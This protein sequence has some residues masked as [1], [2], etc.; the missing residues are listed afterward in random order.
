MKHWLWTLARPWYALYRTL[1]LVNL[2]MKLR[3]AFLAW[4]QWRRAKRRDHQ[5][6]RDKEK[7]KRREHVKTQVKLDS[8]IRRDEERKIE[9]YFRKKELES[10]RRRQKEGGTKEWEREYKE[11]QR[12]H[13]ERLK[14]ADEKGY[15]LSEISS[16][17]LDSIKADLEATRKM[18]REKR[19]KPRKAIREKERKLQE[20]RNERRARK[21]KKKRRKAKKRREERELK[22]L[23][24]VKK[25]SAFLKEDARRRDQKMERRKEA[26]AE[27]YMREMGNR[28]HSERNRPHGIKKPKRPHGLEKP[29]RPH[30]IKKPNRPRG[31]KK[32]NMN[33]RR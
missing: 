22:K 30:G 18:K 5:R 21:N 13:L 4:K 8:L 19:R 11:A 3:T 15:D 25:Y 17:H 28:K 23:E 20:E 6:K 1:R 10:E 16:I 27:R 32:P 24:K 14:E 2:P 26:E 33:H 12:K 29:K 9:S 31:I 7:R